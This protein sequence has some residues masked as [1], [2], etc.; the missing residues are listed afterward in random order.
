MK[1][2]EEK[3]KHCY[4]FRSTQM[5]LD[6]KMQMLEDSSFMFMKQPLLHSLVY[7][8]QLS[9]SEEMDARDQAVNDLLPSFIQQLTLEQIM[10]DKENLLPLTPFQDIFAVERLRAEIM[11]EQR[12]ARVSQLKKLEQRIEGGNVSVPE[13]VIQEMI[14]QQKCTREEAIAAFTSKLKGNAQTNFQA[15]K[16][17]KDLEQ[18]LNDLHEVDD[19]MEEEKGEKKNDQLN[20]E[21]GSE[22][23]EE[24][25]KAQEKKIESP[26]KTVQSMLGKGKNSRPADDGASST[27]KRQ[28]QL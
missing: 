21:S 15:L 18:A 26:Q 19:E 2:E 12:R 17:Q 14:K 24:E 8:L 28:R 25:P 4:R 1:T 23:E 16:V 22:V 3:T 13:V 20:L 7:P 6:T 9:Y 5:V 11:E 27:K 10:F